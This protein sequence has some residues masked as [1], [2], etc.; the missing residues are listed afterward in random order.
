MAKKKF[1]ISGTDTDVGKTLIGAGILEAANRKGLR[2][3]AMKPIAA[4]CEQTEQGLR[5][6]DALTLIDA[7]SLELPYSQVNPIAFEPP[8]A[9]HIA[10][11]RE[12]KTLSVSRLT[13]FCNGIL[14]QS[15][16][17]VVI[18]GAGG[19]RVPLN[20]RETLA[21]LAIELNLPVVMVVG[22]RLG[23]INHAILTAEAI[24]RD[25]LKVAGWVANRVDP[26][27]S[28]YEENLMTLKTLIQAPLLGEVPFLENANKDAVA[29]CLDIDPLLSDD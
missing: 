3:V 2:T 19:W 4:G 9:P 17:F 13:G 16:D 12:N 18:E 11:M 27:M 14:M 22:M 21:D 20:P 26:E 1:F 5:N 29:D 8:I 10:A 6:E 25:G 24:E 7:M 23:C 28:C 15:S